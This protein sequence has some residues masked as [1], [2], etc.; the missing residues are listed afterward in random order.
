MAVVVVR[1]V[2]LAL[3]TFLTTWLVNLV[4]WYDELECRPTICLYC[5]SYTECNAALVGRRP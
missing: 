4:L 2:I 5:H 3:A 1:G